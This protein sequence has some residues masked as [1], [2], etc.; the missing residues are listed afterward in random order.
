M[1]T[2]HRLDM[3]DTH[4]LQDIIQ[5]KQTQ[6]EYAFS[7]DNV[8]IVQNA[9]L[10]YRELRQTSMSDDLCFDL[11]ST[12]AM[13]LDS[14]PVQH[15]C[16]HRIISVKRRWTTYL[17][18]CTIGKNNRAAN[19]NAVIMQKVS[20]K[21]R[22]DTGPAR[23]N[24]VRNIESNM[25]AKAFLNRCN[26]NWLY[27]YR[28][29]ANMIWL[30]WRDIIES[31]RTCGYFYIPLT[32]AMANSNYTGDSLWTISY[33][34]VLSFLTLE[35]MQKVQNENNTY[36]FGRHD[37][38]ELVESIVNL[39]RNPVTFAVGT[40]GHYPYLRPFRFQT[41]FLGK[42]LVRVKTVVFFE[43]TCLATFCKMDNR[44]SMICLVATFLLGSNIPIK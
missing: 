3:K 13:L 41:N 29:Q 16:L 26:S 25:E 21:L 30:Q 37:I 7:H 38:E 31:R 34:L 19:K 28:E 36:G 40:L 4:H 2:K 5:E 11:A 14:H 10:N 43:R 1:L 20:K 32:Q 15:K 39:G 24:N 8:S 23:I 12:K 17:P 6:T 22:T 44:H 33:S 42:F 27:Y 35:E 9:Y 18:P